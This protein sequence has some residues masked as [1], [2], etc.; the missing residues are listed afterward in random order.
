MDALVTTTAGPMN[1]TWHA[2]ESHPFSRSEDP[3]L[4]MRK[5]GVVHENPMFFSH[6]HELSHL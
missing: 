3:C 4:A 6:V 2:K 5:P 1:D